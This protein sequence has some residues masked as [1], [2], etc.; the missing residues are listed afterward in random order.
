[1]DRIS[2]F[3]S[4]LQSACRT[5][6]RSED[7]V[8]IVAVTKTHP[9]RAMEVALAAGIY[10]LGE[11]RVQEAVPKIQQIRSKGTRT[12]EGRIP[13]F[14]LIGHLQSNKAKQVIQAEVDLVHSVDSEHLAQELNRRAEA[15]GRIQPILLQ[16]SVTG[17]ET[18]SGLEPNSLE[19]CLET[20]L[21]SLTSLR[22]DGFMT[23][24]PFFEDGEL[25]RPIFAQLRE[26]SEKMT[27]T[28]HRSPQFPN[29][30]LSMGMTND[31]RPAV[32]EGATLI[33]IGSAFFGERT[34]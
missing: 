12:P 3:R 26:L 20:I 6:S 25:A 33:R 24:A 13:Q 34:N 9:I 32:E 31:W 7:S 10:D 23:M 27:Q 14:H 18:K 2:A 11:N 21:S 8:R 4:E 15:A 22:V 29:T 28:F 1:M 5:S 16:V 19:S 17:E 30:H